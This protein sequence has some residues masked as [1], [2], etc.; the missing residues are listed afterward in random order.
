MCFAGEGG[1]IGTHLDAVQVGLSASLEI[2]V[3]KLP[4]ILLDLTRVFVRVL[5]L[6]IDISSSGTLGRRAKSSLTNLGEPVLVELPDK[7]GKVGMPECLGT[8]GERRQ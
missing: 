2:W 6:N 8:A 1:G 4:H 7:A 3:L 5:D